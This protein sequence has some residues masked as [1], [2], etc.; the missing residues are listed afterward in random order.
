[1]Y[2]RLLPWALGALALWPTGSAAQ[3]LVKPKMM[4]IFDTSGSMTWAPRRNVACQWQCGVPRAGIC[5][6]FFGFPNGCAEG[7]PCG[8]DGLCMPFTYGDGSVTYPGLDWDGDG[9][10]DDSRMYIA[11]EALK[12]TLFGTAELE[13]GLMRYTQTEGAGIRST[14]SNR[15]CWDSWYDVPPVRIGE[16]VINY[17]G[18]SES[19]R[20]GEVL[21]DIAGDA[22]NDIFSWIDHQESQPYRANGN[23]ELRGDGLTPIAGSL[24]SARDHFVNQ[25]IPNDPRRACRSYSI[26]LLTDGEE[27]CDVRPNGDPDQAALVGAASALR[28]LRFEGQPTPVRTFVIGFG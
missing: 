12:S 28:D 7:V 11:K 16:G 24:R 18:A 9:Q 3:Q 13:F 1:M 15:D 22:S 6:Y 23:R 14:C 26:L 10:F 27:S 17:D 4:V 8:A 2:R 19:C 5:P 25:V 21:V 20:G